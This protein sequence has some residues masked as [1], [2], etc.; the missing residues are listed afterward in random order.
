MALA[1]LLIWLFFS[2][3]RQAEQAAKLDQT[4]EFPSL[5]ATGHNN[6]QS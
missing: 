3:H 2:P 1:G 6:A 5:A 4:R